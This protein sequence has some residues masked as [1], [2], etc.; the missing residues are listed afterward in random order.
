MRKGSVSPGHVGKACSDLFIKLESKF[1]WFSYFSLIQAAFGFA[2][3]DVLVGAGHIHPLVTL[4]SRLPLD[5]QTQICSW[6]G[7]GTFLEFHRVQ[8]KLGSAVTDHPLARVSLSGD[9]RPVRV[10]VAYRTNILNHIHER[11]ILCSIL[12][13]QWFLPREVRKSLSN[14]HSSWVVT[15]NRLLAMTLHSS[16]E[17]HQENLVGKPGTM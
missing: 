12:I 9:S 8:V 1:P 2:D 17:D 16:D 7:W 15:R 3:N 6:V 13:I 5:G 10:R 4:K 11:P 14:D